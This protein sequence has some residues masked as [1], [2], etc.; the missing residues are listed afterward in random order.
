M[1]AVR[2]T[3]GVDHVGPGWVVVKVT[4]RDT[5]SRHGIDL[6]TQTHLPVEVTGQGTA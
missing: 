5:R 1:Q 6:M 4:Q 2:A 3:L